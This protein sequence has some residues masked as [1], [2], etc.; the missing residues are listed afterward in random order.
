MMHRVLR[1]QLKSDYQTIQEQLARYC[2]E[3]P[4][5]DVHQMLKEVLLGECIMWAGEK[6]FLIGTPVDYH[7]QRKFLLECAAGDLDEILSTLPLIEEEVA[8]WGFPVL[9]I[10][11]RLGWDKVMKGYGFHKQ[12][13]ILSKTLGECNGR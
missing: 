4:E 12:K 3:F 6:S 7:T 13:V 2:R 8:M 1:D 11:G 5:Y 9:E 10:C